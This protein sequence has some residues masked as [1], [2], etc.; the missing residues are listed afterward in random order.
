MAVK[1][2][3]S[4][5]HRKM[6]PSVK[7]MEGLAERLIDMSE[8]PKIEQPEKVRTTRNPLGNGKLAAKV[9]NLGGDMSHHRQAPIVGP[10]NLT[11]R[12]AKFVEGLIGGLNYSAA[13]REA[14][15]TSNMSDRSV[16]TAACQLHMKPKVQSAISHAMEQAG[17]AL[18]ISAASLTMM[19]KRAYD[20]AESSGN[21]GA[22]VNS[23]GLMAKLN[24]LIV[25]RSERKVE[26]VE[27][28]M[29]REEMVERLR[30]LTASLGIGLIDVTPTDIHSDTSPPPTQIGG[31]KKD[32]DT[33]DV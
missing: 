5:K 3:V 12:E 23:V 31:S 7:D 18:V 16:N 27:Q 9:N 25:D 13:Y 11:I 29:G 10:F 6:Q 19:T 15:D 24:G 21:P 22:M 8:Q 26:H 33:D 1:P 17:K 30:Q 32:V 14:Y 4:V 28:G 2:N 20:I